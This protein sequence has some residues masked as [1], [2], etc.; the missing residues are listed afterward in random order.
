M[1][2]ELQGAGPIELQGF[3]CG[4]TRPPAASSAG[5]PEAFIFL[6]G[7]WDKEELPVVTVQ[8][9]KSVLDALRVPAA[10]SGTPHSRAEHVS[11]W[12]YQLPSI[13]IVFVMR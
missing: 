13:K 10:R 3:V 8:S 2:I 7:S 11:I 9:L 4:I 12:M 5:P 1:G 6:G